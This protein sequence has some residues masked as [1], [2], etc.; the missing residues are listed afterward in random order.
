MKKTKLPPKD[1]YAEVHDNAEMAD[2]VEEGLPVADVMAFG[3]SAGYTAEELARMLH[4][5]PRTYARRVAAKSRLK[6]SEGERAVR[7]MRLYDL[8]KQI[9]GTDES[10]RE[11]LN[12]KLIALGGRT[13]LQFAQTE[14]G[15]R[16]VENVIG[17]LAH[18]VYS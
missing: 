17:R 5:P 14:P 15:A 18:G 6:V 3:R 9:F 4:I 7:L 12:G 13:P 10:T 8:A 1:P 11:W 16:E 2:R